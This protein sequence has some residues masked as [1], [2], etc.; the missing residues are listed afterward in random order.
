[1][2]HFGSGTKNNFLLRHSKAYANQQT[3]GKSLW[4]VN[5]GNIRHCTCVA[6]TNSTTVNET[7]NS[8]VCTSIQYHQ[9]LLHPCP[10]HMFHLS[11]LK[12]LRHSAS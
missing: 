10:V 9:W 8:K 4:I 6:S 1:M 11:G 12:F 7:E 2:F 5:S 3:I